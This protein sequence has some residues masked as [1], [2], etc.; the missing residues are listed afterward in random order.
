[1]EAERCFSKDAL[2]RLTRQRREDA[3]PGL[4]VLVA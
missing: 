2:V 4:A 1:M 3:N